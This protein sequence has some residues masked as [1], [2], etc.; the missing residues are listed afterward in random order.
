MR[1][2]FSHHIFEPLISKEMVP[3]PFEVSSDGFPG[4]SE[5]TTVH[6]I[7][8]GDEAGHA[9]VPPEPYAREKVGRLI[10][11]GAAPPAVA[12]P[13]HVPELGFQSGQCA[14]VR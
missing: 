4:S 8:D 3:L 1:K 2:R 6:D 14:H 5:I 13:R 11:S 10:E 9:A 12:S 7:S